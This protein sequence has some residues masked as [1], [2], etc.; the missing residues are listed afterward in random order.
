MPPGLLQVVGADLR[1]VPEVEGRVL[2]VI[3]DGL[4][5]TPL[6]E[7]AGRPVVAE[8]DS[9]HPAL[10]PQDNGEPGA[11]IEW[12]AL[13]PDGFVPAHGPPGGLAVEAGRRPVEVTGL[14][15]GDAGHDFP[16]NGQ[17]RSTGRS[18]HRSELCRPRNACDCNAS[19]L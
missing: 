11:A 5:L 18:L 16:S 7:E 3:G 15:W 4:V 14:G 19:P 9:F 10:L 8:P 6:D 2:E 1:A 17:T 13:D 12:L